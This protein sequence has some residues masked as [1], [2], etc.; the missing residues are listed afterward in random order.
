MTLS[1]EYFFVL[2]DEAVRGTV[3]ASVNYVP[4]PPNE[5]IEYLENCD[6]Q[7]IKG[8][9]LMPNDLSVQSIENRKCH[10]QIDVFDGKPNVII[11]DMRTNEVLFEHKGR[12]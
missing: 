3:S 9:C 7:R 4:V 10:V 1:E 8:V 11:H 12:A 6:T 2:D 5:V